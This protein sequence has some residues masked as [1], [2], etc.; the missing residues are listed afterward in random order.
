[1]AAAL[2]TAVEVLEGGAAP[3]VPDL[4][5]GVEFYEEVHR[6]ELG[7]IRRALART[8]GNQKKAAAVLGINHTTLHTM[9]RRYQIDPSE[10]KRPDFPR[11]VREP[12]PRRK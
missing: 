6:F 8:R 1:M 5:D 9:M 10:F 7:L 4:S 11:L 3:G 2:S 12:R